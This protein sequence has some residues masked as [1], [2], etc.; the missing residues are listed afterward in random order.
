M[1]ITL[2]KQPFTLS[3]THAPVRY[4]LVIT[5]IG[6]GNIEKSI[7]YQLVD[8][9]NVPITELESIRPSVAGAEICIDFQDDVKAL[10]KTMIPKIDVG[11]VQNDIYFTKKVK[12]KFGEIVKNKD[13]CTTTMTLNSYSPITDIYNGMTQEY[14]TNFGGGA[15]IL[16]HQPA[17]VEQCRDA[18]NYLWV[19]GG[20][21]VIKY[22]DDTG[23]VLFTT[24]QFANSFIP[25]NNHIVLPNQSA[26]WLKVELL[27][28]GKTYKIILKDCN[29]NGG[30]NYNNVM[31]LDPL[32]GRSVMSF[33]EVTL[34]EIVS[35]QANTDIYKGYDSI[36]GNIA[37]NYSTKTVGGNS[38]LNK[39]V[40]EKITLTKTM[41]AE[42]EN[43]E[44]VKAFLA[45][46]GYHIQCQINGQPEWRKFILEPGT[47]RYF[48]NDE[49]IE[50]TVSGFLAHDMK[51]HAI[52][53]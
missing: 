13:T 9:F 28:L 49:Q 41:G 50:L 45:S 33:D 16:S 51:T 10:V 40:T 27:G 12:L 15:R 3:S 29:C 22:S 7:G 53:R 44:W 23:S 19:V 17:V 34:F 21:G 48:D 43:V 26:K 4:C 31:F 47:A 52:D 11:G 30:I 37:D 24:L 1:A 2:T 8:E 14:E 5:D 38:I 35:S 32:G 42:F 18:R 36:S 6:S 39:K 25:F 20:S 46:S